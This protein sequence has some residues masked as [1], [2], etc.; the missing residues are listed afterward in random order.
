MSLVAVPS[1]LILKL[2]PVPITVTAATSLVAGLVDPSRRMAAVV[3]VIPRKA[4]IRPR[5]VKT[6]SLP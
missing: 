1:T 3:L 6:P 2:P 5:S 4:P